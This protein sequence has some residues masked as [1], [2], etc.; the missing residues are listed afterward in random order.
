MTE[1]VG[2]VVSGVVEK[3]RKKSFED[4]EVGD[5]C[6]QGFYGDGLEDAANSPRQLMSDEDHRYAS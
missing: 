4:D 1:S 5:G 2:S 6:L 3:A